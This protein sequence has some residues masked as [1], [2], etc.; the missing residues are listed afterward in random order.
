MTTRRYVYTRRRRERESL[1]GARGLIARLNAAET[2]W[3]VA[4]PPEVEEEEKGKKFEKKK[5]C[6]I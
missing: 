6:F 1:G 3:S 4:T 5:K 2:H